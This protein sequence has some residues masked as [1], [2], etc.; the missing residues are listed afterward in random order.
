MKEEWICIEVSCD[1]EVAD[2]LAA[3]IS[4][5]FNKNIEITHEG[6]RFYL[7]ADLINEDWEARLQEI[8][9]GFVKLRPQGAETTYNYSLII[10]EGW[11]DRWKVHFKPLRV[12]RHFI[13]CPTWERAVPEIEDNIILMDPGRAFGTGHHETTRLCLEW[14]EEWALGSSDPGSRSLLDVGCGTG[15]LAIGAALLGIER[16][17]ALDNDPEAIEVATENVAL[18]QLAGRIQL[19]NATVDC[20]DRNDSFDVI[21]ANIQAAPL[22]GLA[23]ELTRKLKQQGK[24]ALSGILLEQLADVR[25]AYEKQGMT[26]AGMRHAGEWC[27]LELKW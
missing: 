21:L 25:T 22:R 16:V 27:L 1:A 26:L 7:G 23:T 20:I 3:E 13:V 9:G 19:V 24:M 5:A 10:E 8:L 15:I 2:D 12:G 4:E 14:L 6:I 17:V 11:A 18:N